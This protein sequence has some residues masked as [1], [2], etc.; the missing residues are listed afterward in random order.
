MLPS[1]NCVKTPSL[2]ETRVQEF[3][4]GLDISRRRKPNDE[5]IDLQRVGDYH[6]RQGVVLPIRLKSDR[7]H[8]AKIPPMRPNDKLQVVQLLAASGLDRATAVSM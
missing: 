4:T 6:I 5:R 2:L 1:L 8:D 3:T 7:C